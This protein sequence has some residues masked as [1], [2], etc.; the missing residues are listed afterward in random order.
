M[1]K[2][3]KI[4]GKIKVEGMRRGP[5]GVWVFRDSCEAE[6]SWLQHTRALKANKKRKAKEMED[7]SMYVYV[8]KIGVF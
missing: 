8:D 7:N 3:K 5:N 6:D 2:K 4:K 1:L